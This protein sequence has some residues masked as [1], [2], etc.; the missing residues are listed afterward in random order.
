MNLPNKLTLFRIFLVPLLCLIWLFPYEELGISFGYLNFRHVTVSYLNL[1][2]LGIFVIASLTDYLDGNIAR[3]RNLVTT[4]GKPDVQ[5][6]A[7]DRLFP[8]HAHLIVVDEEGHHEGLDLE[9]DRLED[10]GR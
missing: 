10:D 5:R 6:F 2:V 1:I 9:A 4:F 7:A 3:K 8:R